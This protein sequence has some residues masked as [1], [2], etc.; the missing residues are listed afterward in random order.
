MSFFMLFSHFNIFFLDFRLLS[1]PD[2]T[3]KSHNLIFLYQNI[4][5]K[6]VHLLENNLSKNMTGQY[7]LID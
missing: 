4:Q 3:Y 1:H 5:N 2:L 6:L 7:L